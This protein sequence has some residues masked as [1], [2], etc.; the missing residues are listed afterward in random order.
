MNPKLR[1]P[2]PTEADGTRWQM[3]DEFSKRLATLAR[4]HGNV[5]TDDAL[6]ACAADLTEMYF[7]G[8][9]AFVSSCISEWL[10]RIGG[11]DNL[12]KEGGYAACQV[13]RFYRA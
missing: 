10:R 8:D 1:S 6:N 12:V 11:W 3:Y 13:L 5:F 4:E 9:Y 2:L 7:E